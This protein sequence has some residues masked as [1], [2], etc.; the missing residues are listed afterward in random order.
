V[1]K[2][3]NHKK[4]E[5]EAQKFQQLESFCYVTCK[6]SSFKFSS[7]IINP[8]RGASR[9]KLKTILPK[10]KHAHTHKLIT[11]QSKQTNI[12][13]KSCFGKHSSHP[14]TQQPQRASQMHIIKTHTPQQKCRLFVTE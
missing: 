3:E 12:H 6:A 14:V 7:S 9:I 4:E 11:N 8:C 1:R 10:R 2:I 13:T 5:E